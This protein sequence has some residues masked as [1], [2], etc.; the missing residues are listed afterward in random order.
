MSYIHPFSFLPCDYRFYSSG[1]QA[2]RNVHALSLIQHCNSFPA[3]V[4]INSRQLPFLLATLQKSPN[5]LL[6]TL[7]EESFP[8]F[9]FQSLQLE[10][11]VFWDILF[12]LSMLD[13]WKGIN[14]SLK[15]LCIPEK[16]SQQAPA[17]HG[18]MQESCLVWGKEEVHS[19]SLM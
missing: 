9:A 5:P 8:G 17:R 12:L 13:S 3:K 14:T 2:C 1:L 11:F 18:G 6:T 4:L 7:L 10:L 15:A 16:I 19:A